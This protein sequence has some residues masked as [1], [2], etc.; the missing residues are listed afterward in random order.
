MVRVLAGPLFGGW[1][2]LRGWGDWL[3]GEGGRRGS[4]PAGW[5]CVTGRGESVHKV[6]VSG[7]LHLRPHDQIKGMMERGGREEGG[8]APPKA[9]WTKGS[10]NQGAC[11]RICIC[12]GMA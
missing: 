7:Q 4:L 6:W 8:C 9:G 3:A 10:M 12:S 1:E 11:A 5:G 2:H